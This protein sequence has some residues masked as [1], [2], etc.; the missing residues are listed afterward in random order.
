[1]LMILMGIYMLCS[2]I[3]M[4]IFNRG[5][6]Q[7]HMVVQMKEIL[8]EKVTIKKKLNQHML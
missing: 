1:M 6:V 4:V 7:E 3:F 5:K 8:M 2:I